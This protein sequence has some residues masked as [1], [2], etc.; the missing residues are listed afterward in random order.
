[1]NII[2]NESNSINTK[3]D[4]QEQ[5]GD[6]VKEIRNKKRAKLSVM[7]DVILKLC[8][9]KA[10]KLMELAKILNRNDVGIRSNYLNKLVKL[11][12]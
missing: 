8:A 5:T 6:I 10:M 9:V 3:K 12:N 4:V 11:K 1:V 7:E 2:N